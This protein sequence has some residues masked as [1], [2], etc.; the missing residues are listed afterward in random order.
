MVES[1]PYNIHN[2]NGKN[3]KTVLSAGGTVAKANA[4]EMFLT[5]RS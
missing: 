3:T 1:N 2:T 4:D 5:D